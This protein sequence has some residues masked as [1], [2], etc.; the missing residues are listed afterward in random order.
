MNTFKKYCPNVFVAQCE[1]EYK[2][3]EIILLT[4]KYG[5]EIENEVHNFLG[6]TKEGFFLY[7]I[8]RV[9]GFNSQER[10]NNKAEKLVNA[11]LN[12]EKRSNSYYEKSQEGKDFLVLGEPIK[13]G[14]HSERRHRKLIERNWERMGKSVQE[15]EKAEE[16]KRRS[17]YW[18]ERANKIDL[19]M[20]DCLEFYEFELMKA[21]EYHKSLKENPELRSHSMSLQ[22]ANKS[23]KDLEE[24]VYLAVKLWGDEEDLKFLDNEK[25]EKAETKASKSNELIESLNELGAFYAFNNTQLKDGYYQAKEKG[26]IQEGEKVVNFGKG[27]FIPKSKVDEAKKILKIA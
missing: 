15:S 6:K 4:T 9:D 27:L 10:A 26:F 21:K 5:K 17:E 13:I 16:Y 12:A 1:Q 3:G 11:S 7:S 18:K 24:K 22:Y 19:S 8:T 25:K 2:K 20:P 14:H 23:V